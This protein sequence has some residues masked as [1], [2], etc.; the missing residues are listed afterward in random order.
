[1]GPSAYMEWRNAWLF[2][3]P[4]DP[5]MLQPLPEVKVTWPEPVEGPAGPVIVISP[6]QRS[7]STYVH[8]LL[9]LHPGL[10]P[11][12]GKNGLP[13]EFFFHNYGEA[14]KAYVEKTTAAWDTWL[15]D[16]EQRQERASRLF[17][18]IG[19]GMLRGIAREAGAQE[20][21]RLL[22]RAPDARGIRNLFHLFP[23]A[24][25]VML[26]RDGRDTCASFMNSWGGESVFESFAERWADRV[27]EMLAFKQ[28]AVD[29]GYGERVLQVRY[30]DCVRDPATVLKDILP[31]TDLNVTAYPFEQTTDLPLL[32]TS[33][34]SRVHWE[35]VKKPADFNPL[36]RWKAWPADMKQRFERKAGKQLLALG[37]LQG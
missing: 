18:S 32:G 15:H 19:A 34:A 36:E 10:V 37:Y 28:E 21:A 17:A 25:V 27:E 30:E 31:K 16:K 12:G 8:E 14:L 4:Q 11:V 29:H 33:E 3:E 22:L 26:F 5:V 23:G 20:N 2:G 24:I 6:T 35:P 9:A 13:E 7:G 1:M